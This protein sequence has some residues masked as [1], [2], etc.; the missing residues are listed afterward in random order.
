MRAWGRTLIAIAVLRAS[1]GAWVLFALATAVPHSTAVCVT[2]FGI[3]Q[4]SDHLDG[5]IARR[6][7]TPTLAGYLQDS[8]SDKLFQFGCL[9][10]IGIQHPAVGLFTWCVL[11]RDLILMGWRVLDPNVE[12]TLARFKG[13]SIAYAVLLRASVLTFFLVPAAQSWSFVATGLA[14]GLLVLAVGCGA[15]GTAAVVRSGRL[16]GSQPR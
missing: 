4:F 13:F 12:T 5:W 16:G 7:S 10:G 11:A 1:L 14:Y 3:A 9:L 2:A 6:F 8:I 15:V